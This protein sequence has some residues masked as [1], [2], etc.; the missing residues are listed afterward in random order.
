MNVSETTTINPYPQEQILIDFIPKIKKGERVLCTSLGRAQFAYAFIQ[1]RPASYV[2]CHYLD[3]YRAQLA[4]E[5]IT[6]P[7]AN[8]SIRCAADFPEEKF[9]IV[10]LPTSY[11]DEAELTRE[12][13]QA[14]HLLLQLNG[15]MIVTTDNR[16]DV[17]I[18]SEM[19]K[20][21]PKVT[22]IP[23]ER[24]TLY[25]ATKTKSLKKN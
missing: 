12:M 10:A 2:Y 17:W 7:P 21:F 22:R 25:W 16:K 3:L 23:D 20:I 8:L 5:F 19:A 15:Q 24:G 4:W 14:G 1:Q 11:S 6:N 13:M 9:D 18:G